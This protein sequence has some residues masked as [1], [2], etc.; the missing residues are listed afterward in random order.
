MVGATVGVTAK[1]RMGMGTVETVTT[2]FLNFSQLF[3]K[4]MSNSSL[5][6]SSSD[7][8]ASG[9]AECLYVARPDVVASDLGGHWALLDLETSLYYTLNASGA[10]V[11]NAMQ[12][13][14]PLSQLISAVTKAFSVSEDDCRK[15]IEALLQELVAA[16]LASVVAPEGSEGN[17]QS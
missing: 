16:G 5:N 10:E 1:P 4:F 7:E 11:W 17:A 8:A 12:T 6:V 14:A 2:H 13:P 9:A 3:P 15:D